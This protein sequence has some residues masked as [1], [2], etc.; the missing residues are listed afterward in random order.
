MCVLHATWDPGGAG[1]LLVWAEPI[2]TP[3]ERVLE[4]LTSVD[5][6]SSGRAPASATVGAATIG[7]P[8]LGDVPVPSPELIGVGAATCGG[9]ETT[10]APRRRAVSTTCRP[11]VVPTLRLGPVDAL[12]ALMALGTGRPPILAGSSIRALVRVAELALEVVAGGRVV[13]SLDSGTGA[14]LARWAPLRTGRDAERL[15]LLAR[16]LPGA[17]CALEGSG[18]A[19]S[20]VQHAFDVLVDALCRDALSNRSYPGSGGSPRESTRL[21]CATP[22]TEAVDAWLEALRSPDGRV[23]T[24]PSA[25]ATLERLV[26]EWRAPLA[27]SSSAWRLCLRLHEP[28]AP[29]EPDANG[30]GPAVRKPG[31]ARNPGTIEDGALEEP[32]RVELLLQAVDEPTLLV[33]ASEVWRA[34][35]SLR[36]A[37]R[38]VEEPQEVLLAELG[39]AVRAFG[40]LGRALSEPAPTA[41]FLDLEGAHRFLSEVAPALELAGFG[42][43]LP[44]WWRR[45]AA[46]L[47]LR[48]RAAEV[49]AARPAVGGAAAAAAGAAAHRAAAR[50]V[51]G[52]GLAAFE[53]EAALGDT[54]LELAELRRLAELKAP[55]VRVRGQWTELHPAEVQRLVEFLLAGR[56]NR[57]AALADV[58]RA[59]AGAPLLEAGVPV[60]GVDDAGPM[61]ALLRGELADSLEVG[62]TPAGFCGELRAYQRRAVAW[63]RLLERVGLGACLADDMGLGKTAT[64][65]GVLQSDR[66]DGTGLGPTLVVCPTSVMGNWQREAE[67]FTPSLRVAVHHGGTRARGDALQQIASGVDMVVTSYALVD[68]DR[69]ALTSVPWAR[70]VLDEAQQV[71]NPSTKQTQ[72]VRAIGAPRRLALTGTP[73]ENHLG[74]LWSIMEV[75]NPGLLGS[76]ASF[77]EQFAVPIE[78]YEE[79]GAAE[80]LQ[81]ITRPLVLR[82]LKTDR[83]IVPE[84]PEKIETKERCALTREQVTLY[85]AVVD[86]MLAQISGAEG[87]ERRGLVLAAML[88]LKQVCNH[89]AQYAAD[90]SPL[91]GRS[92]KLERTVEILE[93]VRAANERA[94]VFTQFAAMGGLLQ[95][96]LTERLGCRVGFLHGGVARTRRDELVAELQSPEGAMPV[97]VLSV[98]AGGTGLNLTAASHVLH[99]DRWWNP[100]VEDQASDRAYRIGQRRDVQVRKLV[101]VGTIEDRIDEMIEAKRALAAQVV[102]TGETWLTELS[103]D[104]LAGMLRL[105]AEATA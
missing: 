69:D 35:E 83:S 98:K 76:Q 96:H 29:G 94:L 88:R 60:V 48:V 19:R 9:A 46:R 38:T 62:P 13:P 42:V 99:F 54:C 105:S 91:A 95:R 51:G 70:I 89:P 32:W 64:V 101:C 4:V 41:L 90:G 23:H 85:Q 5:G 11:F 93:Q 52:R 6:A 18:D 37:A 17:A 28:P 77:R 3:A 57:T 97:L 50:G 24:E 44:S 92:G 39:R 65:L 59:F 21:R 74:E 87:I 79:Q 55:L 86:E 66:V 33:E 14:R 84:L 71:K 104:E 40:E 68:R 2:P 75:L 61:G 67:R 25:L 53:W 82:R 49:P 81:T 103:D 63:I 58:L 100:A 20:V 22:G 8:A 36:R 15:E 78:R 7:L 31:T 72:A 1:A 102:A 26:E 12:D 80:R 10:G 34:G 27:S 73:V 16:A 43:L 45:P 56:A 47:G 30:R